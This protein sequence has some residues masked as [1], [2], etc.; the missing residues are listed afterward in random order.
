MKT[1]FRL[2]L[3]AIAA[4]IMTSCATSEDKKEASEATTSPWKTG[5]ALYSF[6][7]FPFP[8][9]LRKADSAG[10]K[11]VEGFSFHNL[12]SEFGEKTLL[13]LDDQEIEKLKEF[14]QKQGLSM[15][16]VYVGDAKTPEQWKHYFEMGK[17]VGLEFFVSEPRPDEWDLLDS[18][19][20]EYNIKTAIHQHAKG[21]S[22]YWHPDSVLKAAAG[23]P[24][25]GAC[26]D[27]GHWTRSG[28]DPIECLQALEKN[29]ISVHLKDVS[30]AGELK[31]EY[32]VIGQGVLD[33]AGIAKELKRQNFGGYVYIE[34]EANWLHNVP[35]VMNGLKFFNKIV[36]ENTSTMTEKVTSDH[37]PLEGI[38]H[39]VIFDLK[40]AKNS[41]EAR[42]FLEDGK[43]IL[44]A[45]PSVQKFQAYDQV[46]PKNDFTYGFS[47]IFKDEAGYE[48]YNQHPD[49]VDFVEN[50]WKTEVTRFLEID[51]ENFGN[52]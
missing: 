6:N 24:F 45:I 32:V 9:T 51:F 42:K 17:K 31:P 40:H 20:R 5:V 19:G 30:I 36:T 13:Q 29:L 34:Q 12:G 50:R 28:L 43:R 48:A 38:Q 2:L 41:E 22:Y 33:F 52:L 18:L 8:E 23:R 3:V 39:M 49:H 27:V 26:G 1:T 35:D 21:E 44:S 11:Y 46:S 16:S 7:K 15:R 25:I 37:P 4:S 47:M 14:V 10:L